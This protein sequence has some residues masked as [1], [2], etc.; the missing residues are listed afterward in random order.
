MWLE[1]RTPG[2]RVEH[3]TTGP[4][5]TRERVRQKSKGTALTPHIR[6]P[7][8][9]TV[10]REEWLCCQKQCKLKNFFEIQ[11]MQGAFH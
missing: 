6:G 9:I 4:H 7:G 11:L 5:G 1:P 2:L 3:F 8:L 10:Y